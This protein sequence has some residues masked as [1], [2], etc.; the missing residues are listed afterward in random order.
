MKPTPSV[1][2]PVVPVLVKVPALTMKLWNV[3]KV[4]TSL[5]IVISPKRDW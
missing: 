1:V 5:V 2:A 4:E 3:P